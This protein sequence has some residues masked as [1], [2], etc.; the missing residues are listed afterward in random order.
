MASDTDRILLSHKMLVSAVGDRW[1]PE[2]VS[3]VAELLAD[4]GGQFPPGVR[5]VPAELVKA[6]QRE[7][8]LAAML[9]AVAE[10]GYRDVTVQ[11]VLAHAGVSRP[12]FY[13]HF[14]NK[15][16]CFLNAFD[17]AAARLRDGV[18]TAVRESEGTWRERLRA[19]MQG[20]LDFI[21]AEPDAART[22]IVEGRA[23]GPVALL[24][25]DDLLDHFAGCIDDLVR[26]ELDEAPS[27]IAA[28]GVVGGIEAVLYS[29]LSKRRKTKPRLNPLL[30][31][32]MYFAVLPYGGQKVA[33]EELGDA[34]LASS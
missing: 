29:R 14:D 26:S 30:P 2:E 10:V 32:L 25:R 12:T 11:D 3:A 1:S 21:A 9:K 4:S 19:G 23:A 33:M 22:V 18:S 28:A 27:A 20:L 15:E 5:T 8:M 6:V 13:E 24:R 16:D 31:S 7:R 17:S 34:E